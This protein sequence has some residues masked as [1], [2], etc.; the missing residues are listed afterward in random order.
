METTKRI[1]IDRRI[2]NDRRKAYDLN[3][4]A[5]GTPR[6]SDRRIHNGENV[7]LRV[8]RKPSVARKQF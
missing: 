2:E 1:G 3:Y 7:A 8:D 5:D 4:F 6:Y